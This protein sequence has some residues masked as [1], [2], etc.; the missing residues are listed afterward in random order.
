MDAVNIVKPLVFSGDL[1]EAS[2]IL[3]L[4]LI[5]GLL[6]SIIL[7]LFYYIVVTV[8][9]YLMLIDIHSAIIILMVYPLPLIFYL[10]DPFNL[11]LEI[12]DCFDIIK[13]R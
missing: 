5:M 10:S 3:N 1:L 4:L 12:R 7:N 8:N 13:L 9:L 11:S 6:E 2:I